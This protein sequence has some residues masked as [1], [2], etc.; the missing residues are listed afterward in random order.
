MPANGETKPSARARVGAHT[1]ATVAARITIF[2]ACR[3]AWTPPVTAAVHPPG[4]S[5]GVMS[6]SDV[7]RH[8]CGQLLWPN[9]IA[10]GG[11]CVGTLGEEIADA[12]YMPVGRFE[13]IS[14]NAQREAV[15]E[16]R[17]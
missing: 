13:M 14:C 7:P 8:R 15:T 9:L 1:S 6:A 5:A 11:D 2:S 3:I 12:A 17:M 10:A 16:P 4:G